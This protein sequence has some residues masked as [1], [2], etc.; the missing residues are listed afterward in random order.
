MVHF[1]KLELV[2]FDLAETPL[3]SCSVRSSKISQTRLSPCVEILDRLARHSD[4]WFRPVARW[5][6][7]PT[8]EMTEVWMKVQITVYCIFSLGFRSRCTQFTRSSCSWLHCASASASGVQTCRMG[9]WS[10]LKQSRGWILHGK[11]NS[12]QGR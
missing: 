4:V 12:E 1:S 11:H 2:H 5:F 7:W 9:M 3:T 6:C 8:M 10:L